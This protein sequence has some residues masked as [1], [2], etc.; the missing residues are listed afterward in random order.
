MFFQFVTVALEEPMHNN[1]KGSYAIAI[2][3]VCVLHIDL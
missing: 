3:A 1:G 2:C